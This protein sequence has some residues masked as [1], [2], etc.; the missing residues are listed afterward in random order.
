M[1][2]KDM[3]LIV[4][5]VDKKISLGYIKQHLAEVFYPSYFSRQIYRN[6]L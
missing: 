6:F 4:K 3:L 5:A 2:T 1:E